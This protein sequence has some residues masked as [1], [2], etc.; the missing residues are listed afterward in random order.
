MTPFSFHNMSNN[1]VY[2]LS[3]KFG[4]YSFDVFEFIYDG[5][6]I[7]LAGTYQQNNQI[8]AEAFLLLHNLIIHLPTIP[9]PLSLFIQF[10][11]NN[12]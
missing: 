3:N 10:I 8:V 12:F 1:F 9:Y 11:G 5:Q 2:N 6:V 7:L 4:L